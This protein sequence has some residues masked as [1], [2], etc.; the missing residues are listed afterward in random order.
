[1]DCQTLANPTQLT[2]LKQ[3]GKTLACRINHPALS[4]GLTM[5]LDAPEHLFADEIASY[6][7]GMVQTDG[8][9]ANDLIAALTGHNVLPLRAAEDLADKWD[10]AA[11]KFS[12]RSGDQSISNHVG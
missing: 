9:L 2:T 11:L 12:Q 1:M 5:M 6:D 8:K 10:L 3:D 7:Q 4:T